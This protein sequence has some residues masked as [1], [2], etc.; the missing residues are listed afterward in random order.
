MTTMLCL[1]NLH[2]ISASIVC[3][4]ILLM[5]CVVGMQSFKPL[6]YWRYLVINRSYT[7]LFADALSIHLTNKCS[8]TSIVSIVCCSRA[9]VKVY[10]IDSHRIVH[11]WH[12]WRYC[13]ANH[14]RSMDSLTGLCC[15][16]LNFVFGI[17]TIWN[18]RSFFYSLFSC[19]TISCSVLCG[20]AYFRWNIV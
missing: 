13:C 20:I 7:T 19:R 12:V 9:M 15:E 5:A 6:C 14:Y 10:W 17:E 4:T 8:F 1:T 16:E 3:F 18:I 11:C 2:I